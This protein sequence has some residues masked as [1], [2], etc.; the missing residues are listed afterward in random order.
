MEQSNYTTSATLFLL[1]VT[2]LI[3]I[4]QVT[5]DKR[6]RICYTGIVF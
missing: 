6:K 4:L 1:I 2:L 3:V 5:F